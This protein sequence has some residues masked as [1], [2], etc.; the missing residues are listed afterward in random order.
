MNIT[1]SVK[2]AIAAGAIAQSTIN[3]LGQA[4]ATS[5]DTRALSILA[6]AIGTSMVTVI[7]DV[8]AAA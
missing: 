5:S 2:Q 4:V 8:A 7:E 1:Q 6:D 3:A